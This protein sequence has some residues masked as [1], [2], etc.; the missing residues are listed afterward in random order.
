MNGTAGSIQKQLTQEEYAES[1]KL[2]KPPMEMLNGLR[3]EFS[4]IQ[5]I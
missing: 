2:G 4:A 3:R 5:D 1:N